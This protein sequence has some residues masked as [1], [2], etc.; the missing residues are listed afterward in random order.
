MT[1]IDGAARRIE[2]GHVLFLAGIAAWTGYFLYD[3]WVA[4]PSVRNLILI[5][6]ASVLAFGLVALV[7]AG[8]FVAP[9]TA[10]PTTEETRAEKL[11]P[12]VLMGLFALYIL[13]L[14]VLGFDVGSFAFVA[15]SMLA[16]GERRW[17]LIAAY[18]AVFAVVVTWLFGW[19]LPYPLPLLVM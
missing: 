13:T 9:A 10:E 6:P 15:L 2:W 11:K 3:T 5:L 19:L 16:D 18:S 4:S 12:F 14:P 1:D 8:L 7:L 17:W